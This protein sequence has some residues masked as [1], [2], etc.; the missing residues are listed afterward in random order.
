[1]REWQGLSYREIA[2]ELSL[3]EG[4]VETLIFRARRSLARKLDRSRGRVWG[5][6]NLGSA[7]AWGKA[8]LSGSAAQVAAATLVVTAG[9]SAASPFVLLHGLAAAGRG[10]HPPVG[11]RAG[12]VSVR[13]H[14]ARRAR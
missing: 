6:S 10:G 12:Q 2:A 1:M 7:L 13:P 8:A 4:A 5:I 14:L 3:S 11:D 9:V